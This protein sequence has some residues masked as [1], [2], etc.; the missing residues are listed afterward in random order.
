MIQ[1]LEVN[2][3]GTEQSKGEKVDLEGKPENVHY[4]FHFELDIF[5]ETKY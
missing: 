4:T 2:L 1:F 5:I 3:L